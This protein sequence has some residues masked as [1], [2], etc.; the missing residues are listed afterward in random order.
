VLNTSIA[1]PGAHGDF[2]RA[3]VG[4]VQTYFNTFKCFIG[5]GILAIP[6]AFSKVG[7]LG[8]VVGI[9]IIGV[10]N[11]YTIILTCQ[12][13]FKIEDEDEIGPDGAPNK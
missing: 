4:V 5:I 3:S 11:T 13:K 1:N 2:G 8:G 6:E 7:I 12:C 10:L 9:I